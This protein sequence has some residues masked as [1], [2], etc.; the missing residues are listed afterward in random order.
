[1]C[2]CVDHSDRSVWTQYVCVWIHFNRSARV[3]YA[4]D[5]NTSGR[6]NKFR[7]AF[8]AFAIYEAVRKIPE[9]DLIGIIRP[10]RISGPPITDL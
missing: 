7:N 8:V 6:A 5:V 9:D 1:M 3:T 10:I 4:A 2:V